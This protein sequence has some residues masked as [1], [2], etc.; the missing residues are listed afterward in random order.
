M[1]NICN[2]T[3]VY[4]KL[5]HVESYFRHTH[6][7]MELAFLIYNAHETL[8]PTSQAGVNI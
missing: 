4:S 3:G 5:I 8:N 7:P 6:L 1:H 2:V